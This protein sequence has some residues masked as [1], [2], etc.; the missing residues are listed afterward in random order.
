M[1]KLFIYLLVFY[2]IYRWLTGNSGR[3]NNYYVFNNYYNKTQEP[4]RGKVEITHKQ[5]DGTGFSEYEEIK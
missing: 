5:E 1:L 3:V 4:K 2:M